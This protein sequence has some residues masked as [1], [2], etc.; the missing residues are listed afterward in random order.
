MIV[1]R[2]ECLGVLVAACFA[3]AALA[4]IWGLWILPGLIPRPVG[5]IAGAAAMGIWC[6]AQIVGWRRGRAALGPRARRGIDQ[7]LS[8]ARQA[9][10]QGRLREA[11]TLLSEAFALNDEDIDLRASRAR[12]FTMMGRFEEAHGEW[13]AVCDLDERGAFR[14]EALTALRQ[15]PPGPRGSPLRKQRRAPEDSP[16]TSP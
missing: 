11:E 2:Q 6:V 5:L 3:G 7:R 10:G 8:E 13:E 4:A 14:D 16:E 15:L 9:V 12:L 1:L